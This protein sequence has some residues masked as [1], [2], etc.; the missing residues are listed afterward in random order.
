VRDLTGE[1]L[2]QLAAS[3]A[4][5]AAAQSY[6]MNADG[7]RRQ[8]YVAAMAPVGAPATDEMAL[9]PVPENALPA[10][11]SYGYPYAGMEPTPAAAGWD[12]SAELPG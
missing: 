4:E 10:A 1:R 5:C 6:G 3:E 2:S 9:P 8:H 12:Y 11:A 7:G